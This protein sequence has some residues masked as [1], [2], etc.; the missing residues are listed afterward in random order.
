MKT[1]Y[2]TIATMNGDVI[3]TQATIAR[4]MFQKARGLLGKM[5]MLPQE[6]MIFYHASSIHTFGMKFPIDVVFVKKSGKVHRI[7]CSVKPSRMLFCISYAT[8]ELPANR[9]KDCKLQKGN[10]IKWF[11]ND[12]SGQVFVEYALI[13]AVLILGVIV[14]FIPLMEQV[15]DFL[16]SIAGYLVD[17]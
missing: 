16:H 6:A 10:V 2:W 1:S 17:L 9:T 11:Q 3:S 12:E 8:I 15:Q 5:K 4:S 13:I 14:A 7:C